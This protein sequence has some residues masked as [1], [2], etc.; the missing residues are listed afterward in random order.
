MSINER[1][2]EIQEYLHLCSELVERALGGV[3]LSSGKDVDREA[4]ACLLAMVPL[5]LPRG[6]HFR[7]T[8]TDEPRFSLS[9][10]VQDALGDTRRK[11]LTATDDEIEDFEFLEPATIHRS[12]NYCPI[13]TGDMIDEDRELPG[14]FAVVSTN[15]YIWTLCNPYLNSTEL[16]IE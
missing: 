8:P 1:D 14:R 16:I 12:D 10:V 11:V 5:T 13:F 3:D 7:I 4:Q 9:M 15:R 2:P 6:A